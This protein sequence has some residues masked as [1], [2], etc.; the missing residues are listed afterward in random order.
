MKKLQ[1]T[2]VLA[3]FAV[4]SVMAQCQAYFL[5]YQTNP[6]DPFTFTF[7]D[8]S[9]GITP[10]ATIYWD[11][12][13]GT[14]DTTNG[15]SITDHTYSQPG[16]YG[17]CMQISYLNC[18][19]FFCDTVVVGGSGSGGCNAAYAY[20]TSG[21]TASFTSSVTGTPPFAYSWDFGDNSS[22]NT[23]NPTHTYNSNGLYGVTLIVTDAGGCTVTYYDTVTI[24]TGSANCAADFVYTLDT[25]GTVQFSNLSSGA[26]D[27][28]WDFGDGGTTTA[29]N[30]SRT[31][32]LPGTYT[33]CLTAFTRLNG[34]ITCVDSVCQQITIAGNNN[35]GVGAQY[36]SQPSALGEL[37]TFTSSVQGNSPISYFWDFGDGDTSSAANPTHNYVTGDYE[38]C[39]FITDAGGCSA[40]FC[41]SVYVG[42]PS[43]NCGVGFQFTSQP[44]VAGTQVSFTSFP[45]NVV[46]PVTYTW[47]FGDGSS[48]ATTANP[49]HLYTIPGTYNACVT[50]TDATGCTATYCDQVVAGSNTN[51]C[52]ANF[53]W[54]TDT[55]GGVYFYDSSSFAQYTTYY[56]DFGDNTIDTSANPYHLYNAPGT[57]NVCL[58]I[59]QQATPTGPSCTS[60]YCDSIT[61]GGSN[62]GNCTANFAYS[63]TNIAGTY[64]FASYLTGY[65]N[66]VYEWSF[67]DG[68]PNVY[69]SNPAHQYA[70]AGTYTVCL[71]VYDQTF[72]PSCSDTI[73][74]TI[75]IP[76]PNGPFSISGT[77]NLR[78]NSGTTGGIGYPATVY[79]IVDDSLLLTAIDSTQTTP[80]GYYI[81][82]NVAPG[83]Y[84]VK[85]ALQPGATGYNSYLPTY[86]G[87][88]LF[89]FNA[90]T[91]VAN[92]NHINKNINLVA[93]N[94]PGGPGFVGGLISQGANKTG[95]GDPVGN[96]PVFLLN[97]DDTPVQ[98]TYSDANGNFE[99]DDIAYGTYQVYAE[100][101]GKPTEPII[102]TIG[103]TAETFDNLNIVV[104]SNKVTYTNTTTGIEEV[105]VSTATFFPNPTT[106]DGTLS[107]QLE[108]AANIQV[109]VINQ[110]GQVIQSNAQHADAGPQKLNIALSAQPQGLYIL[111]LRVNDKPAV[112]QRILK[113]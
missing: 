34:T 48:G 4:G 26:S 84:L 49:T 79:L 27:Y 62:T 29:A 5:H 47:D 9:F 3:L 88:Q 85:A 93:G 55:T 76:S 60:T 108:T 53:M 41:D 70:Q 7:A 10:N 19:D 66:P 99:I 51:N 12:G 17:A 78:N 87:D 94:N 18:V 71:F 11:F 111:L 65:L 112:Y 109:E 36:T 24:N 52:Q 74:K 40:F 32:G 28:L 90:A 44:T 1:F 54:Y 46:A 98:Y 95:P 63:A 89:W 105:L 82:N 69:T 6:N 14:L 31:Y 81:F 96:I 57:Y 25:S 106:A 68:S 39:V 59:V 92:Q 58:T 8:S 80:N 30:P 113:Q 50:I 102:L 110:L 15:W 64:Q 35:C 67:G 101:A 75:T 56:W 13:D 91:I 100:V 21:T 97:M 42:L 38:F 86:F 33:V 103:A 77:V 2:L 43:S 72:A 23:A 73:C 22:G 61:I 37:V 104:E 83:A 107:F 16:L 45:G 20:T